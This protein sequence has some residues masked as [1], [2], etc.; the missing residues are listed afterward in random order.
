MIA[1]TSAQRGG[2]LL[3]LG[4]APPRDDA[5]DRR[6]LRRALRH[7]AMPL[8]LLLMTGGM[9]LCGTLVRLF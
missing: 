7:L 1:A 5:A 6:V 4:G 8:W 2:M 9:R 3:M